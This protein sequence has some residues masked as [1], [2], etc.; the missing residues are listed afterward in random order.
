VLGLTP[1]SLIVDD[2]DDVAVAR[3]RGNYGTDCAQL[4]SYD[5]MN[6]GNSVISLKNHV[7]SI[8]R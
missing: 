6:E 8:L 2:V 7:P 4:C 1:L 3:S 5:V